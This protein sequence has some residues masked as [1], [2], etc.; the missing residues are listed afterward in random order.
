[1]RQNITEPLKPLLHR[2][3]SSANLHVYAYQTDRGEV[4]IGGA[5]NPYPGYSVRSTLPALQ[6]LTSH[7]LE[8]LPCLREARILRQWAGLCDMTPD[9]VPLLGEVEGMPG[10]ILNC[11]WGTW[12]FK[13][14]PAAGE[15]VAAL[16]ASGSTPDLIK[17]F[18]L[19]RF[20]DGRLVNERAAAPAAAIQ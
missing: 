14:A 12:G 5:V 6:T 18:G 17:H 13:A 1:M 2:T 19:D 16:I 9:Y 3:I 8:M 20:A 15:S 11:G 7:L 10:F 4:V